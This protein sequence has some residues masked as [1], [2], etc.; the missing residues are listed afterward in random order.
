MIVTEFPLSIPTPDDFQGITVL[1]T[2]AFHERFS[3]KKD[4]I[5][6]NMKTYQRYQKHC[7]EKIDICRVMKSPE[8]GTTIIAAIQLMTRR[9]QNEP[10]EVFVEWIAC[11]PDHRGQGIGSHL[12]T[13]AANFAK[14]NLNAAVLSLFVVRSNTKAVRLYERAGF[15]VH[16]Q[17]KDKTGNR[18]S[19]KKSDL[20]KL[21]IR[22]FP[23]PM[24]HWTVHQMDKDLT[25]LQ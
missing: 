2:D 8:D 13:W 10:S 14:Q 25:N 12:L 11:H 3:S 22:A 23:N 24:R 15:M 6:Q 1:Q 19:R 4:E 7:P 5:Q 16:N 9:R 18:T 20:G 17:Q 21:L